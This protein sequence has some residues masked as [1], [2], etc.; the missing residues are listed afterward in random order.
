M[1]VLNPAILMPKVIYH[2]DFLEYAH[3]RKI[4]YFQFFPKITHSKTSKN[5]DQYLC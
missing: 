1:A 3:I 5:N 2:G 4:T